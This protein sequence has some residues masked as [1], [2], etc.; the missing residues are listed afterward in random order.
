MG[1][2]GPNSEKG[3]CGTTMFQH[4]GFKF[5]DL[6]LNFSSIMRNGPIEKIGKR[7]T[8]NQNPN[9]LS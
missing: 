6:E 9:L 7:I 1:Q 3:L 2:N 8:H 4:L 5:S